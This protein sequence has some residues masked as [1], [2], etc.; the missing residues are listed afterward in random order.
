[1][2][3][4]KESHCCSYKNHCKESNP[5]YSRL[6]TTQRILKAIVATRLQDIADDLG[7]SKVTVSKVLRGSSDVGEETRRRVKKRVRELGYQ[8]NYQARALAGGKTFSIGLIVPDLVHPFFAEVA[9]GLGSV[10]RQSGRVLLLSSSEEDPAIEN[11]EV[12]ALFQRGVDALLI[13][14]CQR[15]LRSIKAATPT[16][17][18]C[19]LVDRNFPTSTLHHVGSNDY[20]IG[21]I[22]TQHLIET[23][24]RRIAHIGSEAASTGR[25][26]LRAFREVMQA[27]RL[28]LREEFVLIRKRFEETSDRAGYEAMR[29]LLSAKQ[30]PDAVFCYNDLTAIGAMAAASAAGLRI[31]E[32]I[33]FVGCG[34]FRYAEYLRVPL[35]SIE[36]SAQR[37]GETAGRLALDLV[38]AQPSMRK[39]VLLEPH[40]I[41]R[42]SSGGPAVSQAVQALEKTN[43]TLALGKLASYPRQNS[44]HTAL[45]EAGRMERPLFMLE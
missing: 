33:A 5:E 2:C 15:S 28:R 45:R 27:S 31:P 43:G 26:R 18:P 1:M 10:V 17:T 4:C 12:S 36:Q 9:K 37:I 21:E 24:R 23:G 30:L 40:L 14:S 41:V 8:P 32:D 3:S 29:Q 34:N 42:E 39:S 16:N 19:V 25:E 7:I 20:R 11:Q 35:T 13:A 6:V 38:S 44:L 22:A